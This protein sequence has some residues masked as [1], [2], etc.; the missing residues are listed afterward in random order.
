M[1]F[2]WWEGVFHFPAEFIWLIYSLSH[3]SAPGQEG[4]YHTDAVPTVSGP[5]D[6]LHA[7]QDLLIPC[8][9]LA[10]IPGGPYLGH[11]GTRYV[12]VTVAGGWGNLVCL[13]Q[14]CYAGQG[15]DGKKHF[16]HS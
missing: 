4:E 10:G 15:K 6:A 8:P 13:Y 5:D 1:G 11:T 2:Y 12:Q 3:C 14:S 9:V 16:R 7:A